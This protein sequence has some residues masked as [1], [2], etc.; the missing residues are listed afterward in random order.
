MTLI[1]TPEAPA[2]KGLG[3]DFT[4]RY[5]KPVVAWSKPAKYICNTHWNG[6]VEREQ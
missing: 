3:D 6:K 1:S 5:L 4:K 2:T